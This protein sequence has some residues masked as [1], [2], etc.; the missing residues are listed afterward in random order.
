MFKGLQIRPFRKKGLHSVSRTCIA[1]GKGSF[2]TRSRDLESGE[3][4]EAPPRAR[5]LS[6]PVL[7]WVM[8]A[9]GTL[10]LYEGRKHRVP[11]G[12]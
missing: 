10:G 4:C 2:T 3:S 1:W 9:R 12:D 7:A 11:G 8:A 6:E 5:A